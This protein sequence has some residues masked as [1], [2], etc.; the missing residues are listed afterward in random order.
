MPT[1]LTKPV[2]RECIT[3]RWQNRPLIPSL[4]PATDNLPERIVIR[5]KGRTKRRAF[6]LPI[7]TV[8]QLAAQH[9]ADE[10]KK[11][12]AAERKARRLARG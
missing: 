4:E 11:R 5:E 9:F 7:L 3:S 6:G 10:E 8:Y 2:T 12:R 1:K